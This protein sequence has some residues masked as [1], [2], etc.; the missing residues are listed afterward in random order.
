MDCGPGVICGY[1]CT[2]VKEELGSKR[3]DLLFLRPCCRSPEAGGLKPPTAKPK[4]RSSMAPPRGHIRWCLLYPDGDE[5]R[6][7]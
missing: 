4:L 1:T 2:Y 5:R 3:D 7:I 6:Q